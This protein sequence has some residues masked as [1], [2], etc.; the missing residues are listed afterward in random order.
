MELGGCEIISREIDPT[1]LFGRYKDY[2]DKSIIHDSTIKKQLERAS[3]VIGRYLNFI[4][5]LGDTI[6]STDFSERFEDPGTN[7][8]A[9]LEQNEKFTKFVEDLKNE[10]G[11]LMADTYFDQRLDGNFTEFKNK[12]EDDVD[13]SHCW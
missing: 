2:E 9:K 12:F 11:V 8:M 1:T 6:N 13:M 10:F 5:T 4:S 7:P 3:D